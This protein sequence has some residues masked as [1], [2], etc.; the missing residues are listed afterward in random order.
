MAT[1]IKQTKEE[2]SWAEIARA[3]E[4][5]V[6]DKLLAERDVI[7][8]NL[9]SGT[10][11]AIM[12]EKVEPGRAWMGFV[13]GGLCVVPVRLCVVRLH[14][15]P[16][17][18]G[19]HGLHHQRR[20]FKGRGPRLLDLIEQSRKIKP[21]KG[22][23]KEP[24][25]AKR[26]EIKWRWEARGTMIGRQNGIIFRI[27]HPWD[28]PER[29]HTVSCYD[30]KGS[31]RTISTAG[32]RKF[33]WEEAVEFCQAIAAGE[34]DLEDLRAEFAAIEAER[35]RQA[36]RK[37]VEEAKEFRGHL[38][39]AGISY[40][41]LL[42]LEALRGNLGSLGHNALLGFERGEGWPDGT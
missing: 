10:E 2:I 15:L 8:F 19:R 30:T 31:A 1:M 37:A 33:T 36:L 23:R 26:K 21:R 18:C 28:M 41:T 17:Q 25:M 13:D 27:Y 29:E 39:A 4:M 11:V 38:E 7:R 20:P 3:R 5:G 24:D 40:N 16:R 14:F 22:R 9:R 35:E 6:L 12:V 34:I 32:Y 42:E